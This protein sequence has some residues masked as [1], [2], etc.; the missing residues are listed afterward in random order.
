ME[1]PDRLQL[2][3]AELEDAPKEVLPSQYWRQL[4]ARN[5]RQLTEE[6]YQTFKRTLA[7]NYFTW[8]VS[9]LDA[10]IT[11]LRR[12][13]PPTVIAKAAVHTLLTPKHPPLTW[14]QSM[15]YTFLTRLLWEYVSARD[16]ERLLEKLEEPEEG[17][18]PRLYRGGRLISQD[19][20]NAVL[21]YQSIL[22]G[23]VSAAGVRTILELGP[24]YGR[25]AYVFLKLRPGVRYILVDIPPALYVAERYLSGL[26]PDRPVFR[27]RAFGA[28]EDVGEEMERAQIVF[29]MPHQMEL[30]PAQSVE[31]FVNISSLH[32]MRPEQVRYYF[33]QAAR[34]TRGYFYFKQWRVSINPNDGITIRE[35]DY[36]VPPSWT[37]LYWR[38]CR[39]QDYFFE[40]LFEVR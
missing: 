10:Q 21:E 1:L 24:G 12:A 33:D 19:L 6:G 25:T 40:A 23:P 37:K 29:L 35:Q 2:M 16:P 11:F 7:R 22:Q 13:L 38:P 9:P 18:P 39:V 15:A 28:Y 5:L 34:L 20:A 3:L 32:E 4:N 31:L 26:F 30:M 8:L 17:N 14:K 27:F 36:P